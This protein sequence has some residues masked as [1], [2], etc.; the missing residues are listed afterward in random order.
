MSRLQA[1]RRNGIV[2]YNLYLHSLIQYHSEVVIAMV[3]R[4]LS[5]RSNTFISK[6]V[7]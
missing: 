5:T 7:T 3:L 1:E 4:R 6:E 2:I